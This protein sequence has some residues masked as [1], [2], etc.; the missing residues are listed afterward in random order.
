MMNKIKHTKLMRRYGVCSLAVTLAAVAS[1]GTAGNVRA[2]PKKLT[3][4]PDPAKTIN[5]RKLGD[6]EVRKYL[7]TLKGFF[8]SYLENLEQRANQPGPVGPAGP[9]GERGEVGPQGPK[10]DQGLQGDQGPRGEKGEQGKDT[11]HQL[12]RPLRRPLLQKHQRQQNLQSNQLSLRHQQLK[13]VCYQ[14]QGRQITHSLLL[15][16]LVSSLAQVS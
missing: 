6:E 14:L 4:Y 5:W 13:R 1:L 2:E 15:Q 8:E 3:D 12:H 9:R 10:G 7:H 11:K 16:L